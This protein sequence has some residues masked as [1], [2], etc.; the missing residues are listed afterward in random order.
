[1]T[2]WKAMIAKIPEKET[3]MKRWMRSLLIV[4]L[5]LCMLVPSL[6]IS[7]SAEY[8]TPIAVVPNDE[9]SEIF[10]LDGNFHFTAS[11]VLSAPSDGNAFLYLFLFDGQ[12]QEASQNVLRFKHDYVDVL[13]NEL[14]NDKHISRWE[15][16]DC[17]KVKPDSRYL[18]S[19]TIYHISLRRWKQR[20]LLE[21][22]DTENNN[23]GTLLY[24]AEDDLADTLYLQF[25]P[26]ASTL[27]QGK[28]SI[29]ET[30][31]YWDT[32]LR[33]ESWVTWVCII[34]VLLLLLINFL[35]GVWEKNFFNGSFNIVTG[36]LWGIGALLSVCMV[37]PAGRDFLNNFIHGFLGIGWFSIPEPNSFWY[38]LLL[39]LA[40]GYTIILWIVVAFDSDMSPLGATVVMLLLGALHGF[41]LLVIVGVLIYLV[42]ALIGLVVLIGMF[43][44]GGST[45]PKTDASPPPAQEN[46][47][48]RV[49]REDEKGNREYM[50]VGTSG[51]YYQDPDTG[52]WHRIKQ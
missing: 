7:A 39:I 17:T 27:E 41:S 24:K 38:W 22:T 13:I 37:F 35:F 29:G 49:W 1:M 51:E 28:Y 25:S 23:C 3:D 14:S 46:K 6:H 10:Q 21:I 11:L 16:A 15:Q 34:I 43:S 2:E 8:S 48:V 33:N 32:F 30:Q 4:A 18:Q 50:K 44:G 40:M 12:T 42:I 9:R 31:S 20:I 19:N 45:D 36:G 5:L 52:E 26:S 47:V